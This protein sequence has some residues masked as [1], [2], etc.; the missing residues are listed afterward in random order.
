MERITVPGPDGGFSVPAGLER[1]A[2]ERLGRYEDAHGR[3]LAR[4]EEL[5]GRRRNTELTPSGCT[6]LCLDAAMAGIGSNSCGPAL[7]PRYQVD[8]QELGMELHLLLNP[9]ITHTSTHNE[10]KP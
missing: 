3:L 10:V 6:V 1:E 8:S 9:L 2:A 7:R 5:A 4:Q